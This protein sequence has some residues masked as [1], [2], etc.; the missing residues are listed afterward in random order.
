MRKSTGEWTVRML[1]DLRERIDTEA[2]YQRGSVWSE[3]QQRLLIDSL[4]R[5]YDLPK[6]YLRKLPEGEARLYE[7][8]DGKQRLTAIWRYLNDE[9]RLSRNVSIDG[10]GDVGRKTWCELSAAAQDRLQFAKITVSELEEATAEEVA[11]LFLRL[12]RGEPL[13]AAEKRN[14]IIGPVRDFVAG[15]LARHPV[16]S[17]LGIPDRRFTWHELS[18]IALLLTIRRGPSALK[19]ADLND[20][21]EDTEFDPSGPDATATLGGLDA[22]DAVASVQSGF[23]TTRWGF[24]DLF[25]CLMRLR[26][27]NASIEPT[28]VMQFFTAFETERKEAATRLAELRAEVSEFELSEVEAQQA[29]VELPQVRPDM[30]TYVQAFSREGATEENVR[31]RFEVMYRRLTAFASGPR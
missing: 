18:A 31:L 13:R 2:E 25:L 19:G 3:A 16:F 9:F 7:V 15:R 11:E 1:T 28:T 10:I 5:G 29:V 14:A 30:F 4:L 27:E 22:L 17:H 12:Q 26:N 8:V 23:I 24:V 6:I 21:Y 20:L